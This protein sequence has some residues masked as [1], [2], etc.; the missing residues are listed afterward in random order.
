MSRA[1]ACPS[2]FASNNERFLPVRKTVS[3]QASKKSKA[4][5]S[6]ED[7]CFPYEL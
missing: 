1:E 5:A 2:G 4:E 7:F 6:G 3:R